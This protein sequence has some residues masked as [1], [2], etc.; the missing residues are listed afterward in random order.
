MIPSSWKKINIPLSFFA[1]N[2]DVTGVENT[3][4]TKRSTVNDGSDDTS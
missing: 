4:T 3:Y 1:S 2:V